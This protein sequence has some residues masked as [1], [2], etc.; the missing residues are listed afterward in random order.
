[1]TLFARIQAQPKKIR[2]LIAEACDRQ[3]DFCAAAVGES[4]GMG[5]CF[6]GDAKSAELVTDIS[7]DTDAYRAKCRASRL[8]WR[9]ENG[10]S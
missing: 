6:E 4:G 3:R 10:F 9:A 5:D 1:M 8:T 7:D 2:E